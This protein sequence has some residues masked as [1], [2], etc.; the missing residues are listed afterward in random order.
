MKSDKSLY[1]FKTSVF[2][3]VHLRI[4]DFHFLKIINV[5]AE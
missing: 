1:C 5:V 4:K 3:C 2:I